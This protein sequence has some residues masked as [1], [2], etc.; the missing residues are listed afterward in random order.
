MTIKTELFAEY[1]LP[2]AAEAKK[3]RK[4][5]HW[6][7]NWAFVTPEEFSRLLTFAVKADN[8]F[9]DSEEVKA[10]DEMFKGY[11]GGGMLRFG[12]GSP[13]INDRLEKAGLGMEFVVGS[14]YSPNAERFPDEAARRGALRSLVL[15][16]PIMVEAYEKKDWEKVIARGLLGAWP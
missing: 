5:K 8:E 1:Y 7:A 6:P 12:Q 9:K 14:Y 3:M 4:K 16:W 13:A 11:G 15:R 2:T 10:A